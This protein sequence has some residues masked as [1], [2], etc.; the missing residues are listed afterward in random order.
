MNYEHI[1]DYHKKLD[2]SDLRCDYRDLKGIKNVNIKG[3]HPSINH[4]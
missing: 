2:Q 1:G 3:L 4:K